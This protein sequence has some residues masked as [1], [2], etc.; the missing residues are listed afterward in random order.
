[1][2]TGIVLHL[3][4][5]SSNES[6]NLFLGSFKQIGGLNLVHRCFMTYI[7]ARSMSLL[8]MNFI[9]V[10]HAFDSQ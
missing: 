7:V 10:H 2:G 1:M 6:L 3:I 5:N 4:M 8:V 9:F